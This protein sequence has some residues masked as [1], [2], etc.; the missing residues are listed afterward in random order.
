MEFRDAS[1]NT[2][3]V[4]DL[5]RKYGVGYCI[6]SAPGLSFNLISTADFAYIRMHSGGVETESNYTEE[7]LKWW[8]EHCK[9][10]LKQ[11]D[12]YIY[13]NNDYKGFAIYN[14]RRLK[15]LVL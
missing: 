11:G 8:A 14:A 13:F 10:L 2:D 7:G 12:L 6:M 9:N 3:V 4:F 1:W 5:L 15:E